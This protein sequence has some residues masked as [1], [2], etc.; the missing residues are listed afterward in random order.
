MG[1]TQGCGMIKLQNINVTFNPETPLVHQVFKDFNLQIDTG[2][3]VTVIGGNGAGKST[4][5]NVISG[6]VSVDTGNIILDEKNVTSALP[7]Q[8]AG[9][10]SRVFQ[11][12]LLGTFADLTIEENLSLAYCRGKTRKLLPALN[13]K[14]RELFKDR[15][16]DIGIGLEKRLKDKMGLLSGGQRQAVSLVMATLQPSKILLLDEHTAALDPKMERLILGLT[17]KLIEE[18]HLTALMITHC[19]QQALEFGSRTLVMYQ[20]NIVR[21]LSAFEREKLEPSE[22]LPYF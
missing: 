4:L 20:G 1:A 3:F 5:M 15:L 16:A 11:D 9:V 22:L 18:Q 2:E 7:F 13:S 19:M 6:E 10:I 17:R 14:L 21:D 12:P 8:R